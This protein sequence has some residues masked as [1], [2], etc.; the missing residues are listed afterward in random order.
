MSFGY[1]FNNFLISSYRQNGFSLP[2]TAVIPKSQ[3]LEPIQNHSYATVRKDPCLEKST[4]EGHCLTAANYLTLPLRSASSSLSQRTLSSLSVVDNTTLSSTLDI[5]SSASQ[6]DARSDASVDSAFSNSDS[7]NLDAADSVNS[8]YQCLRGRKGG[9]QDGDVH[10][11]IET[12]SIGSQKSRRKS[13]EFKTR[14]YGKDQKSGSVLSPPKLTNIM[15]ESMRSG[16]WRN[17]RS[18]MQEN[19]VPVVAESAF[20]T[21]SRPSSPNGSVHSQCTVRTQESARSFSPPNSFQPALSPVPSAWNAPASPATPHNMLSVCVPPNRLAANPSFGNFGS[22]LS[23]SSMHQV[24]YTPYGLF[25]QMGGPF[26]NPAMYMM[27][28]HSPSFNSRSPASSY[29]SQFSPQSCSSIPSRDNSFQYDSE[30]DIDFSP[31][32]SKGRKRTG[33]ALSSS[34]LESVWQSRLAIMYT[35]LCYLILGLVVCAFSF[36]NVMTKLFSEIMIWK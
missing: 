10:S 20:Q 26:G 6:E 36:S 17:T 13:C 30:R 33:P 14:L 25:H 23:S 3:A 34:F 16:I 9:F 4:Q 1:L 2:A 31:K 29:G 32:S 21:L 22:A 12:L 27:P 28:P 7:L 8:S 19:Q 18:R 15:N 5:M 11:L 35:T 24:F